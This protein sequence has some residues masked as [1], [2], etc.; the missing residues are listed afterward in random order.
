MLWLFHLLSKY[1]DDPIQRIYME[2]ETLLLVIY[3]KHTKVRDL[4]GYEIRDQCY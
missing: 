1:K 3:L 2:I 4:G